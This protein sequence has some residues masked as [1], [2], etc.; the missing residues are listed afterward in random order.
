MNQ[1]HNIHVVIYLMTHRDWWSYPLAVV[2]YTSNTFYIR[3]NVS[4]Y[5]WTLL[6]PSCKQWLSSEKDNW[7]WIVTLNRWFTLCLTHY[8][9]ILHQS[10][11]LSGQFI[12]SNKG[13]HVSEVDTIFPCNIPDWHHS[14]GI[15]RWKSLKIIIHIYFRGGGCKTILPSIPSDLGEILFCTKLLQ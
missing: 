8:A 5:P 11:T 15:K 3:F 14:L 10:R 9:Q 1:Y 2:F 7:T 4:L 12:D 13:S 6:G